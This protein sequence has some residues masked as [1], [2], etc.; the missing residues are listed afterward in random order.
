MDFQPDMRSIFFNSLRNS[1]NNYYDIAMKSFSANS[2][3][4][5]GQYTSEI[6]GKYKQA[7]AVLA[8]GIEVEMANEQDYFA[9]VLSGIN[10]STD[11]KTKLQNEFNAIFQA[12]GAFNYERFINLI[13][14][15]LLGKKQYEAILKLE[16]RRLLQ[17]QRYTRELR[18]KANLERL[19]NLTDSNGNSLNIHNAK[20][21]DK[22]LEQEYLEKHSMKRFRG[23]FKSLLP[24]VDNQVADFVNRTVNTIIKN[25]SLIGKIQSLYNNGG[26]IYTG[27]LIG[28]IYNNVMAKL[29]NGNR[30]TKI[31]NDT[32]K[33][34]KTE[35][36][37][38]SNEVAA[39]VAEQ[40]ETI[41]INNQTNDF[42][43]QRKKSRAIK[44]KE[45][46]DK[47]ILKMSGENLANEILAAEEKLMSQKEDFF[48]LQKENSEVKQALADLKGT[49]ENAKKHIT[50][51]EQGQ[52]QL[53]N[54]Y[55]IAIVKA[56]SNLS[57]IARKTIEDKLKNK[58]ESIAQNYLAQIQNALTSISIT[59]SGPTYSE[60][61]DSILAQIADMG[62]SFWSGPKLAKAD[63]IVI[64]YSDINLN[65]TAQKLLMDESDLS[66]ILKE[67]TRTI[68]TTFQEN[69]PKHGEAT[70]QAQGKEA[71]K[72]AVA[73]AAEQL[74]EKI[75]KEDASDEEKI[76]AMEE[77]AN[78]MKNT[79]IVTETMKTF[80]TY[81]DKIGFV[82]GSMGPNLTS[83]LSNFQTMF[84]NAGVRM[85]ANEMAWLETAIVN[86]SPAAL[87]SGNKGPI[88]KYLSTM[89]GFAVFDEGSAELEMIAQR[90]KDEFNENQPKLLH[91]YKLNGMY[92]PGSYILSRIYDNL[93]GVATQMQAET[94]NNDGVHITATAT[95]ALIPKNIHDPA[96]RW[97]ATY[98][99]ALGCTSIDVSFL[100]GLFNVVN[101]LLA[102]ATKIF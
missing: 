10:I 49:L 99:A 9:T 8:K 65:L 57:R 83:Q 59:I 51:N 23:E 60:V 55:K 32:V 7:L 87:G 94:V 15:I 42:G 62:E 16:K 64:T 39:E 22:Y 44:E 29:Q 40:F 18:E 81:Y 80:D 4:N 82:A 5:N 19:A 50:I 77:V 91:I 67:N 63:S 90:I 1:K 93:T 30:I 56:K 74:L 34:N 66:D 85:T 6:M 28:Q 92:F 27:D 97:A 73:T 43:K 25:Q 45:E 41:V 70:N 36:I 17:L 31:I 95:E 100:S 84:E 11:I 14:T 26:D 21:L 2:L 69:L 86:C 75:E 58:D 71:Y 102:S 3:I 37:T 12:G 54:D 48:D 47:I 89:A 20:D 78:I 79:I 76:K 88:E 72:T 13:N 68:Y 38:L 35:I 33:N 101:Q 61:V 52:E 46:G 53:S 96:A 24:T 98:N